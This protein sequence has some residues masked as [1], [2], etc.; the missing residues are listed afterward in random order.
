MSKGTTIKEALAK[1]EE[2]N[3]MKCPEAKVIKLCGLNPP[4]EKMDSSLSQLVACEKLS[5]SSN[6]IEKIAFLT[7]LRHLKILSVARNNIKTFAGL[8]AVGDV[9][10][11]LW[12]SYNIIE[13][14]K[15]I[16][17][18]KKLRVLYMSHN[19]MKDMSELQR[20]NDLPC[21]R[22]VVL[23]GNPLEEQLTPDD[24]WRPAVSKA[25]PKITK[26]DGLVVLREEA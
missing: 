6:V 23:V 14:T 7:N 18:L 11:E 3:E 22:E 5:L 15:G 1:W 20:M 26:L 4:I 12:I 19:N 21:L 13:K 9:L 10:D 24:K 25:L 17:V 16:G 8:E 2:K